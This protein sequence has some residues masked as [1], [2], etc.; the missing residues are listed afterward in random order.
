MS[1]MCEVN[2]GKE[3]I[4]LK[5]MFYRTINRVW[6]FSDTLVFLFFCFLFF[7]KS[8]TVCI[9]SPVPFEWFALWVVSEQLAWPSVNGHGFVS[10]HQI[11][12]S[13]LKMRTRLEVHCLPGKK[14]T[15]Y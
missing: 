2:V 14:L 9:S 5:R 7:F 3:T 15:I 1:T 11:I 12:S 8:C 4:C 13:P 10:R 6:G